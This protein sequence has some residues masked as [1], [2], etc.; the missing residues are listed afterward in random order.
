MAPHISD[1]RRAL[2]EAMATQIENVNLKA[3]TTEG[4]GFTG[5]SEG[6]ASHAVAVL[7]Q[8]HSVHSQA[9]AEE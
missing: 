4:M 1:M 2:A 9:N 6:I 3:K 8:T 7:R 5:R